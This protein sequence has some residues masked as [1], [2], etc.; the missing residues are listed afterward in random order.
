MNRVTCTRSFLV[1]YTFILHSTADTEPAKSMAKSPA[2]K[3]VLASIAVSTHRVVCNR[4]QE[5]VS[6]AFLCSHLKDDICSI[7]PRVKVLQLLF[8]AL[9]NV[10]LIAMCLCDAAHVCARAL[11]EQHACGKCERKGNKKKK[12]WFRRSRTRDSGCR[13]GI[14]SICPTVSRG[15]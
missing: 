10:F 11:V 1:D 4:A 8:L 9:M 2:A 14:N 15:H 3:T 6:A 13:A 7:I 12:D 5:I